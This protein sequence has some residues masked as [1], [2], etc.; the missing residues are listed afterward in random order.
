LD[1]GYGRR[2]YG[3]YSGVRGGLGFRRFRFPWKRSTPTHVGKTLSSTTGGGGGGLRPARTNTSSTEMPIALATAAQKS[4]VA[5]RFSEITSE[6]VVC[7]RSERRANSRWDQPRIFSS[8]T[9]QAANL[10]STNIII[11]ATLNQFWVIL[12]LVLDNL[13]KSCY[14]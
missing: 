3:V 11:P 9:N 4:Q 2:E 10:P 14:N 12:K 7:D 6:T 8:L 1:R 5:G 13:S